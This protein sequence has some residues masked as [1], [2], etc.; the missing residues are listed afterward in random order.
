[1]DTHC[2]QSN[3]DSLAIW[4]R[5]VDCK[6]RLLHVTASSTVFDLR[7]ILSDFHSRI[8][9]FRFDLDDQTLLR[10]Q[11]IDGVAHLMC[12]GRLRGGA[13]LRAP[14]ETTSSKDGLIITDFSEVALESFESH[15]LRQLHIDSLHTHSTGLCLATQTSS[16]K[17]L[18]FETAT[19]CALVVKGHVEEYIKMLGFDSKRVFTTSLSLRDPVASSVEPRAVTI[20]NLAREES[21]WFN[22]FASDD[23][24]QVNAATKIMVMF[25]LRKCDAAQ[26]DWD[27]FGNKTAFMNY[28]DE[29]LT[30][31]LIRQEA[32]GYEPFVKDDYLVRKVLIP[33][34]ARDSLYRLSAARSIQIKAKRTVT[35]APEQGLEVIK[36]PQ[37]LTLAEARAQFANISGY[38]GIFSNQKQLFIRVADNHISE[39]RQ[40]LY[41]DDPRFTASNLGVKSRWLF[42]VLGFPTGVAWDTVHKFFASIEWKAIPTKALHLSEMA[43]IFATAAS[44]PSVWKARTDYGPVHIMLLERNFSKNKFSNPQDGV[45]DPAQPVLS[46]GSAVDTPN[47]PRGRAFTS[48]RTGGLK[49]PVPKIPA[50]L[51]PDQ[52]LG[53]RVAA[54]EAQMKRVQTDVGSLNDSQRETRLQIQQLTEQQSS[55]FQSLLAAIQDLKQN[56]S[57]P[58]IVPSSPQ[59]R[60]MGTKADDDL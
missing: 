31:A 4:V 41:A 46:N 9:T 6:L 57:S 29:T 1:M 38:L 34:C 40:A 24:F 50:S 48:Q 30:S 7:S 32:V 19:P 21:E 23:D 25:E 3:D 27:A 35:D 47:T 59:R 11:C 58:A 33:A 43:I 28:T 10:D 60:R 2:L 20:V 45:P 39:M 18:Q 13:S 12:L 5:T 51:A 37:T 42:K 55:G 15:D 53:T 16:K 22:K 56:Q 49:L 52:G 36:I 14:W 8:A 44:N 54:L 17:F 26:E